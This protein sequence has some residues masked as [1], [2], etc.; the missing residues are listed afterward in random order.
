M[1][2]FEYK[3][4]FIIG[5]GEKTTR[6]LNQYGSQGWELIQVVWAWHYFKRP[7]DAPCVNTNNGDSQGHQPN[8]AGN[9][10]L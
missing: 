8:N 7:L 2:T 4:V 6:I 9:F 1:E 5:L 10:T 3:C